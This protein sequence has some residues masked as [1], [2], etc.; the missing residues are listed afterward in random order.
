[1]EPCLM[2]DAPVLPYWQIFLDH[3]QFWTNFNLIINKNSTTKI[4]QSFWIWLHCK[5]DK[6]LS[7]IC[8]KVLMDFSRSEVIFATADFPLNQLF[9]EAPCRKPW[10]PR[11]PRKPWKQFSQVCDIQIQVHKYN[12][13]H[14]LFSRIEL[15][16]LF[17]VRALVSDISCPVWIALATR[18]C[19]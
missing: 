6:Y 12:L 18:H 19:T 8:A 9:F 17:I 1:M 10:K 13:G 4:S 5:S 7:W 14:I 11:K 16:K 15:C 2:S 3:F